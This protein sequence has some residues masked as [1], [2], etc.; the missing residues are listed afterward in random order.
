MDLRNLK[1]RNG[2]EELL[3]YESLEKCYLKLCVE[4]GKEKGVEESRTVSEKKVFAV[5]KSATNLKFFRSLWIG[6]RNIDLFFPCLGEKGE[7]GFKGLAIEVDGGI[8]NEEFKMTKDN[9]KY[10]LLH[11]LR[12]ALYTI[13]NDDLSEESFINF[14]KNLKLLYRLDSRGRKRVMRNVFLY[15]ISSHLNHIVV[16]DHFKAE[17]IS[18]LKMLRGLK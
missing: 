16:K 1:L 18:T 13:E 5:L 6:N 10:E 11:K 9:H 7:K 3:S 2:F 12:I 14:I 4:L 15:T 8:H 17:Q